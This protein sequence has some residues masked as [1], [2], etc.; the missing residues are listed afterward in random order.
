MYSF[1]EK[2]ESIILCGGEGTRMKDLFPNIPKCLIEINGKPFV[3][4][5]I[6][7]LVFFGC[8]RIVLACKE[9]DEQEFTNFISNYYIEN[10][11]KNDCKLLWIYIEKSKLGTGGAI[12]TISQLC[13]FDQILVLNGD[14]IILNVDFASFIE[15]F[16]D[17]N[18]DISLYAATVKNV[19]ENTELN[20][21][22]EYI[23][24]ALKNDMHYINAG[25]YLIKKNLLSTKNVPEHFYAR[26]VS[27]EK[28]LLPYFTDD[29]LVNRPVLNCYIHWNTIFKTI[30][31]PKSYKEV[32]DDYIQESL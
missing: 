6:N 29:S 8:K 9:E 7:Q 12:L 3:T 23:E 27:W 28:Q 13:N 30:G 15:S 2:M 18:C 16:F 14:S 11:L 4:Y 20:L 10:N 5:I 19:G 17:D 25:I 26:E 21:D 32:I 1:L 31:D 22:D 24:H